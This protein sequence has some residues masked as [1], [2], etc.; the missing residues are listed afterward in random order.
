LDCGTGIAL[1]SHGDVVT[2]PEFDHEGLFDDDYLHFFADSLDGRGAAEAD[3]IWCL[4]ELEPGMEVLDLACGHGR[5]ANQ[6]AQRGC[7]V[8]GLDAAPLFLRRARAE[9]EALGVA[10][11]YVQGDMRQLPWRRRFDRIVNWFTAFG[12]FDDAGNK[13]V[14]AQAA[15]ALK[16]GGRIAIEFNNYPALVGGYLPSVITTRDRDMVIDQHRLDPLTSRSLVTRTI[17]RDGRVRQVPFFTRLFTFP[18][19]RDWLHAAGFSAVGG[20]GE[21]GTPLT[22]E[23]RR[24]ITVASL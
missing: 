7:R 16:P 21:D 19:F 5:I 13:Q 20:Y 15:S 12:Y 2:V 1:L 17:I 24:L 3:L 9:A 8:T 6:L 11:D 22:A 14:L 18:E 23:H 10:V 4:L